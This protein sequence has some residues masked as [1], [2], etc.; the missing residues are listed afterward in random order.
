MVP[1]AFRRALISEAHESAIAGHLGVDK[2]NQTLT[3]GYYWHRMFE[4]VHCFI[5]TCVSCQ[6]NKPDNQAPA[7][8]AQPVKV[9]EIPFLEV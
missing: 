4:D 9:T 2:T 3:K 8:Q 1:P 7:G 6:T 5:K